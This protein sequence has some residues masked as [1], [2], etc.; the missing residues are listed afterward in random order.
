MKIY[1]LIMFIV[2]KI[3]VYHLFLESL[4]SPM[5]T[6]C[7]PS[8]L[9]YPVFVASATRVPRETRW[10]VYLC[11]LVCLTTSQRRE[12]TKINDW[13][14]RSISDWGGSP[15]WFGNTWSRLPYFAFITN[16]INGTLFTINALLEYTGHM[17]W[18]P[19]QH[20]SMRYSRVYHIAKMAK[21]YHVQAVFNFGII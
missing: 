16:V 2:I 19:S 20:T 3:Y 9:F 11:T 14:N 6:I 12:A 17:Y 7:T 13:S 8:G 18:D 5:M 1:R 10:S 15:N 21:E 4:F